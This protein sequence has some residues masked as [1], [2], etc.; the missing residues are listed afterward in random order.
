MARLPQ[1]KTEHL[2]VLSDRPIEDVELPP[3]VNAAP[4]V[5]DA[6]QK[7]PPVAAKGPKVEYFRVT[8]GGFVQSPGGVRSMLR[9]GK[10]IDT[11]NYDVNR[12]RQQGIRMER[13][14]P[15]ERTSVGGIG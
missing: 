6:T 5:A 3:V 2:E 7:N 15:E 4:V 12:L 1:Q 9:E 10:E 11:L 8:R 14:Q 13:I